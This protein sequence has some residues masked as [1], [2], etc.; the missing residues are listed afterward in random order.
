[1]HLGTQQLG[2]IVEGL[3]HIGMIFAQGS[4]P[5]F[6][7]VLGLVIRAL[8]GIVKVIRASPL[9]GT[10]SRSFLSMDLTYKRFRTYLEGVESDRCGAKAAST[11][12]A[13]HDGVHHGGLRGAGKEGLHHLDRAPH[14]V[15]KKCSVALYPI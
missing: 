11:D 9:L 6:E 14:H 15:L 12:S 7:Q 13:D 10:S 3:S 8:R 4:L 1:M 2:L 5:D